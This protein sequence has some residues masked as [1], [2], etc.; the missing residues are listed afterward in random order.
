[1]ENNLLRNLGASF[2]DESDKTQPGQDPVPSDKTYKVMFQFDDDIAQV[3]DSGIGIKQSYVI[4]FPGP[5][6]KSS[7]EFT[8]RHTKK[9]F[10]IFCVEE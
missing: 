6:D 10:R 2:G 5:G 3:L 9:K 8:N 1:M 7:I 4:K